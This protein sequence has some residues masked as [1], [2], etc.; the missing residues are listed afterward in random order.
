MKNYDEAINDLYEMLDQA[1]DAG[2]YH[3][4]ADLMAAIVEFRKAGR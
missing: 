3:F 2:L 1:T 4:T